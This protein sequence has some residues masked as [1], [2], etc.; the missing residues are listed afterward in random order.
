MRQYARIQVKSRLAIVWVSLLCGTLV[1]LQ[2]LYPDDRALPFARMNGNMV[3]LRDVG[4]LRPL[5]MA[6]SRQPMAITIGGETI[7]GELADAG[8]SADEIATAKRLGEYPWYW[9]MVPFSGF[10][11]G[12][13]R[14]EPVQT[15]INAAVL[16]AYLKKIENL[17]TVPPKNA[18]LKVSG[19]TVQLD[20]AIDGTSCPFGSVQRQLDGLSLSKGGLT[21]RLSLTKIAP[22]RNDNEVEPLVTEAKVVTARPLTVMVAGST[23]LVP[24]A[25]VASWLTIVDT[26]TGT[27]RLDASTDLIKKY[28][29]T[30]QKDIYVRPG[31]TEITTR[32]GIEIKRTDGAVGRGIDGDTSAA[33]VT[34]ALFE[35]TSTA[36]LVV[37]VLPPTLQYIRSYSN[38]PQGL[39]ALVADL[40]KANNNMAISVRKLGDTGVHA[41]GDQ[42]YHPASTYKLFVAYSVLKRIDSGVWTWDKPTNY[43]NVSSCFDRMIVNSDN[44]CAEW[45]GG[46]IGWATVFNE[47]RAQG[48]S[49][50]S[51]TA[52]GFLSTSN[53]LALFL[54][55]LEA[56]QLGL[57]EPS[58]A[59]LLEAMKRQVYRSGIPAG[60]TSQVADKVGFLDETIHDAAI[61]Y[62]PKGVYIVVIMSKGSSWGAIASVARE[63]HTKMNE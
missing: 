43:G 28:F 52:S 44:A 13:L 60:V 47:I 19:E 25:T 15:H 40:S 45:F 33:A 5:L 17:C 9:R 56:N 51:V 6:T 42:Q 46:T 57:T 54:Q 38:T 39:Q 10:V 59:R 29:E 58:R 12:A 62:S 27:L 8:I 7:R 11:I 37:A 35:K 53:D 4:G 63:I 55:K 23:Y 21:Y 36:T 1:L 22:T 30:I 34:R 16:Q 3:G 26:D 20:K 48:L 18:T 50:S 24:K 61:V 41:L 14:D 49:K 32:D 2:L 31:V